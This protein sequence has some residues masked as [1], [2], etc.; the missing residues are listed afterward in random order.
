MKWRKESSMTTNFDK[1][2]NFNYNADL[3]TLADCVVQLQEAV[4]KI[5]GELAKAKKPA[6][7][8]AAKKPAS[9]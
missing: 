8:P 5:E 1:P 9:K 3:K 7:K 2:H 4:N 6:R